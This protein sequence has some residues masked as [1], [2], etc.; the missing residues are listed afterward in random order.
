[1]R[2]PRNFCIEMLMI[3]LRFEREGRTSEDE[4]SWPLLKPEK[5]CIF[6]P[7]YEPVQVG[8]FN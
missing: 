5:V 7:V 6:V 2:I 1:M 3:V 4:H 8:I